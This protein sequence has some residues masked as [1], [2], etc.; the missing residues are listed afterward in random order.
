MIGNKGRNFLFRNPTLFLLCEAKTIFIFS[1]NAAYLFFFEAK[2][3]MGGF[4]SCA[5]HSLIQSKCRGRRKTQGERNGRNSNY[6]FYI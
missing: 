6:I 2:E 1:S 5:V 3:G 4:Y